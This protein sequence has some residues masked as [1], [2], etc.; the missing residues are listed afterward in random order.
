MLGSWI[1]FLL[2]YFSI[3]LRKCDET[4][5]SGRRTQRDIENGKNDEPWT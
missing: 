3:H 4:V 2:S 5:Q 1:I